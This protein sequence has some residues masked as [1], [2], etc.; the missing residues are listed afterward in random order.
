VWPQQ[1]EDTLFIGALSLD[2]SA[3]HVNPILPVAALI[4]G[5]EVIPVESVGQ[6]AAHPQGLRSTPPY[7][8]DLNPVSLPL[9]PYA[10]DFSEIK[11]QEHVKRDAP[12]SLL[13]SPRLRAETQVTTRRLPH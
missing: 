1:V 8:P 4:D 13:R 3:R 12:N 10:A 9:P 5:P 6:L 11:R 2:D 7:E